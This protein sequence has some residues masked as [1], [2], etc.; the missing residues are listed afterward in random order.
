MTMSEIG[1]DNPLVL[2]GAQQ[3]IRNAYFDYE[4]GLFTL[5]CVPGAGKSVVAHHI[6][7]E[8]ILRRYVAGDPTPE[9]HVAVISFNRDEAADIVPKVCDRLRTIV[10]HDLVSIASEV[11]DEELEYLLQRTRQAPYVGTVDS[12][13]RGV[14]QEIS[15]DTGFEEMPSV[16]ND[17]L[18]HRAHRNCYEALQD[19][20]DHERRLR[21]LEA[22][23]PE[24]E[25][26]DSVAE[27][28]KS[29][30]TFCRDQRLSTADFHSELAQTRDATYPGGKSESFEDIV[31]SV[32]RFVNG[33]GE[34]GDDDVGERVRDRVTVPDQE[35]LLDADR[36][37]YDAWSEQIDDFCTILAAYRT[38]YQDVVRELGVVSHTDVA[39]LVDA[40]FDESVDRSRLPEPLREVNDT[41]RDRVLQT[42]QSRIRSLIIDEAQDVS[43][44]QHAALSH[45]VTEGSRVFACGDVRQGIYLW[46]HADPTWFDAAT[47][48]GEYLGI[49]WDTHENRTATTSYRCVPDIAAGINAIGEPML[50][51]PARGDLGG[52]DVAYP[53]LQAARD[54][55]DDA[56]I[57]ISAFNGA[58]R[59]GTD[60]WASPDDGVGEADKLATHIAKGLADGT[61]CDEHGSPLNVTVLFRRRARMPEY[62]KAFDNENLRVRTAA[63]G[64]FACPAVGTVF[65]VCDWLQEPGSPEQTKA[66]LTGSELGVDIDT[67]TFESHEWDIDHAL[68]DVSRMSVEQQHVLRGLRRLR[69]RRDMVHRQPASVYIE[70]IIESLALRADP[71]ELASGVAPAQ[72][73]ANLD[74]LVETI[75]E[76]EGETCYAPGDLVELVQP[77]FESPSEGPSQPSTTGS[78]YDVEFRTVHDAKGDQDDVVAIADPGFNVWSLGPHTQRFVTQ[79]SITGIAP[80]TSTDVPNDITLPPFDGGLYDSPGGWDRDTGLRWATAQWSNTVCESTNRQNLVGPERLCRVVAN[81]RAEV[82]RL[83]YVALTRARDH[84]IVPL[85]L[86]TR[87][88]QLRDRW[89]DTIRDGLQFRQKGTDSYTLKLDRSDPNGDAIEIG[90]NDVDLFAQWVPEKSELSPANVVT[91]RP[92]PDEL[93]QWIPRFLNPS[94]MYPLTEDLDKHTIPHL[95]GESLH[96]DTNDVPDDLPLLFDQ[97]GPEAVGTCLHAVLTELVAR[98]ITETSLR[99]MNWNVRETFDDVIDDLAS[100][101]SV[102]ERDG[103]YAFFERVL[104]GFVD[105][106]LWERIEDPRTDVSVERPIDGLVE[107]GGV[108]FEIHGQIDFVIEYPNGERILSDVK[109]ALAEPTEKTH[110]RYQLQIA[111]YTYL[112]EQMKESNTTVEG[113]VETFGVTT[114]TTTSS[115]PSDIIQTRLERFGS[116][117]FLD[118]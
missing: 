24:G 38:V 7:A 48:N 90:V 111:A 8:D 103:M 5:N 51:D 66:L 49:S 68:D 100:E 41:H 25:Y 75:T 105:S 70:E 108:E 83:L 30:V 93:E 67:D 63:E 57:H 79:G 44:I 107:S 50:T 56:A 86:D 53:R 91:R 54:G 92:Q 65:A 77:F 62:K 96:T 81:E 114:G 28:L 18:L 46:R 39:Y 76:W 37:L 34:D 32:E 115:W 42:Y 74:A 112:S 17:A 31:Q 55:D 10:E 116:V 94:T 59:P 45:I 69:D 43:A 113:T 110:Q 118:R 109:I 99:A 2:R 15:H 89:L 33:S 47:T 73:V 29:A 3:A 13:L 102:A 9:Q 82:W 6:A 19:D 117:E 87:E 78:E 40:Y 21:D 36:Q 104:V 72:R 16:G 106:N 52:L 61:F 27:M 84:L 71:W 101:A 11:T 23:Y 88:N 97:L 35:R 1:D 4:T 22:A 64:L 26:D 60:T 12:L 85:P 98:G 95:L 58:G 80:P 14:L 20:P